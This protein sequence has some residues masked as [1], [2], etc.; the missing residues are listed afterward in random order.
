MKQLLAHL[1]SLP[2]SLV[3]PRTLEQSTIEG[4]LNRLTQDPS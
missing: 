2:Y 3:P 4:G 1:G